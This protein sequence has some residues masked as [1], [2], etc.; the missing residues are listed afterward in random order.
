MIPQIVLLVISNR[1]IAILE[2]LSRVAHVHI[3]LLDA[4]ERFSYVTQVHC[5]FGL[6]YQM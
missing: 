2:C 5:M 3:F 1:T 4:N 6:A